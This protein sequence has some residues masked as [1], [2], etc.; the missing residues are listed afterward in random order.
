MLVPVILSGGAGTR[1]WPLSRKLLPKQFLPLVTARTMIQ[2][3]ALRLAGLPDAGAPILVV[4]DEQRFLAAEQMREIGVK[5]AAMLLEPQG[6]NTA[7]AIA[8]AALVAR[9]AD[10]QAQLLVLPSDH[11]IT[12]VPAFHAAIAKARRAAAAGKLVTFGMA[13]SGPETGFGYIEAGE[14][15]EGLPGARAIKRFVE[16]PDADTAR[17]FLAQGRFTWNSGMF[18]FGAAAFLDELGRHRPAILDAA[19]RAVDKA[20][21]DLDFLRLEAKAFA[22]APAEPVDVAVMEK[23]RAGAVIECELGWSDVGS[24]AR[25]W[26]LGAKDAHGN[27]A[28]GDVLLAGASGCY[29]R[30]DGR[31]VAVLGAKDLV[32]VETGDALLVAARERAQDVKDVVA[33]LEKE[34]RTEHLS[35]DRVYRPWGYYESVDAGERFLVKRL[36]VKPGQALSLQRHRKRAEHWVVVAGTARVTRDDEV[37]TVKENQSV[38]IPLGAKHRLENPGA[39]PLYLVEVQSGSYFGEDDIERFDDKYNRG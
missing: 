39:E 25:L 29:V 38:F 32:I 28:K 13:P 23:T 33:R 10:P 26:E 27:V 19:R 18:L 9:A 4:G 8:A 2:D 12:D 14:P 31:V 17:R 21:R 6:R 24:F 37:L 35:H 36:M 5:P 20:A 34:K 16:K 30:A 15:L 7:P 22:E 11:A 3:T 1:L